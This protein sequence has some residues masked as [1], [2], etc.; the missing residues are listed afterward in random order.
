MA[1]NPFPEWLAEVAADTIVIRPDAINAEAQGNLWTFALDPEQRA[2]V[3]PADVEEFVRAV[4]AARGR[5]L[6]ERGGTAMWFYCWHDMQAGQLRLSLISAAHGRLPFAG[7]VERVSDLR[8]VA[9]GFLGSGLE[10][11]PIPL[12]VWVLELP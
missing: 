5:A 9:R 3:T 2:A 7:E 6:A 10:A 8:V 12:P 1:V 4:A 11:P